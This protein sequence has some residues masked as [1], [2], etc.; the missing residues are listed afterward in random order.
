M[1]CLGDYEHVHIRFTFFNVSFKLT[2]IPN[3]KKIRNLSVIEHKPGYL[4]IHIDP[5]NYELF[6]LLL[7]RCAISVSNLFEILPIAVNNFNDYEPN[8]FIIRE[9]NNYLLSL[10]ID[11]EHLWFN[12]TDKTDYNLV[13]FRKRKLP[14]YNIQCKNWVKIN[15]DVHN[16]EGYT[17]DDDNS[18]IADI[19]YD[20]NYLAWPILLIEQYK[21]VNHIINKIKLCQNLNLHNLA[22]EMVLRAMIHPEYC[23]IVN[24]EIALDILNKHMQSSRPLIEYC[25][26]YAMYILRQ[27]ET[28][29]FSH[30]SEKVRFL[31]DI[32]IAARWPVFNYISLS[33][34]P[35]AIQLT[36]GIIDRS[37]PL[38]LTGARCINDFDTFISRF[39]IATGNAFINVD[40]KYLN[41]S[42]CGSILIPCVHKNPLEGLFKNFEDYL[43]YYYPGYNSLNTDDYDAEMEIIQEKNITIKYDD[44]EPIIIKKIIPKCEYYNKM[45]DIDVSITTNNF[46]T[47]KERAYIIYEQVVKNC[48]SIGAVFIKE[49][50]SETNTKFKIYGPGLP[51]PFDIF[52]T[53]KSPAKLV[54]LFHLSA[55]RMYYDG[56]LMM[57]RSCI[58]SLLSGVCESYK[59]HSCRKVPADIILKYVIRGISNVLNKNEIDAISAYAKTSS[60]WRYIFNHV[61]KLCSTVNINNPIFMSN[62][63]IRYGLKSK[64]EKK[65][66]IIVDKIV[67][68][69]V[70]VHPFGTLQTHT[71][72]KMISPDLHVIRNAVE[73]ANELH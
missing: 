29:S 33:Q 43:D 69:P 40:F 44:D 9:I 67:S 4:I 10:T 26:T 21:K 45:A 25:M 68:N 34:S 63:G 71:N 8:D 53:S 5:D 70:Y 57:Y 58:S 35:Y 55:V 23:H 64:Y 3:N 41:A 13:L 1:L 22:F 59:I 48:K 52:K 7:S 65:E 30:V 27:E 14:F 28:I 12:L 39:N 62:S 66:S 54:K 6:N 47:F 73:Y 18:D 60:R 19:R 16:N 15:I 56:K 46:A 32:N 72:S 36:D 11:A 37:I 42:V 17:P 50:R 20:N 24:F 2:S 51:R 61:A 49:E 31:F 38:Y